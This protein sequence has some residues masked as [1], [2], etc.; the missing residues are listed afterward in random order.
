M[1]SHRPATNGTDDSE[2]RA[3]ASE[4]TD[5]S[6]L[7]ERLAFIGRVAWRET[8]STALAVWAQLQRFIAYVR[9][10]W[11]ARRVERD[12][13]ASQIALGERIAAAQLGD[14]GLRARLAELRERRQ[15]FVAAKASTRT[16]DAEL[17]GLHVLLAEPFLESVQAPAAVEPEHRRALALRME[18][19]DRR[20]RQTVRRQ[21]LF[22][23]DTGTR[24]RTAVGL[25]V[26]LMLV[27][28]LVS[29]FDGDAAADGLLLPP[30]VDLENL[31]P[32]ASF[33]AP[34]TQSASADGNVEIET[35]TFNVAADAFLPARNVTVTFM[36]GK[37]DGE[38]RSVD[39]DG[40]VVC[41][42]HY[43]HGVMHGLRERF[44]PDG[45]RF[46][47]L[48]FDNGVAQGTEL[49]Y[50][51]NGNLASRT[52]IVDGVP[53]GTSEIKFENGFKCVSTMYAGGLPHGQRSHFRP[54]GVC[55]AI[56]TWSEGKLVSQE[57]LQIEVTA[58]DVAAIAERGEFSTR[59]VDHW[60]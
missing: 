20:A 40:R 34:T 33:P 39:K 51:P 53:H 49:V 17:R 32:L 57:F 41:I 23:D 4:P 12:C 55:F 60:E 25:G 24:V 29:S 27:S 50:F 15:S 11:T 37:A 38:A 31:Q 46:S 10:G 26:C 21:S 58:A 42:E 28:M 5:L 8:T 30:T 43:R 59:L 54:D 14:A 19:A 56:A 47:E 13:L 2:S 16:I 36:N 52:E 48:R 44:Y 45:S 3:A 9:A 22:P 18:I 6:D 7:R 35:R 1:S